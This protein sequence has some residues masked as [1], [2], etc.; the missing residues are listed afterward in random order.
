MRFLL[1]ILLFCA[2]NTSR[3][4]IDE[5]KA[6]IVDGSE[7]QGNIVKYQWNGSTVSKVRDTIRLDGVTTIQL[8]VTDDKGRKDTAT[9]TIK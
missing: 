6:V 3:K 4:V 9:T 8:I 5:R 7:S 1:I 2:C